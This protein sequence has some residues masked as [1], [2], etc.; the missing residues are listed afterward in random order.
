MKYSDEEIE[1]MSEHEL[2]EVLRN[3]N[4]NSDG[5]LIRSKKSS[6]EPVGLGGWLLLF[7][8]SLMLAAYSYFNSINNFID[9]MG[10]IDYK[11]L[12]DPNYNGYHYLWELYH[13]VN[14]YGSGILLAIIVVICFLS[15]KQSNKLPNIARS[16]FMLSAIM[17]GAIYWISYIINKDLNGILS[18]AVDDLFI[19]L[20]ASVVVS[21]LWISYFVK[22]QRVQNTFVMSKRRQGSTLVSNI[23]Y[24]FLVIMNYL[25]GIASGIYALYAVYITFAGGTLWPTQNEY[26]GGFWN[27]VG[28]MVVIGFIWGILEFMV[29]TLLSVIAL[30]I[31]D[32]FGSEEKNNK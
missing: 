32:L 21:L 2:R 9:F 13:N 15:F 17:A 4:S 30:I 23:T 10:T 28:S 14:L 6:H 19:R 26:E 7:Y 3:N 18:N 25:W 16:F 5:N 24:L 8:F 11:N 22:S 20:I 12:N 29:Q 31:I 27:G 1:K